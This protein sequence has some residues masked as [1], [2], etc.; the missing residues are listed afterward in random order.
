MSSKKVIS[1]K[2]L[3]AKIPLTQ[4]AVCLLALDYYNASEW[5]WGAAATFFS[6][7]W[8]VRIVRVCT[9]VEADVLK[10]LYPEKHDN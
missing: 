3:P 2:N 7:I 8:I 6:I 9:Q 1:Y 10:D 4:S 5:V